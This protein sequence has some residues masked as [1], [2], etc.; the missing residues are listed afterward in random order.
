[1][2]L[3]QLTDQRE[4]DAGTLVGPPHRRFDAMEPLEDPRQVLLGDPRTGVC[5]RELDGL[6]HHRQAH[7]DLALQGVLEGVR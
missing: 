3:R 7:A 1:V 6:A 5:D 2:E 4:T